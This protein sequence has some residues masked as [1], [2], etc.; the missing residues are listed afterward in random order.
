MNRPRGYFGAP[1]DVILIDGRTPEGLPPGVPAKWRAPMSFA[2]LD[3]RPIVCDFNQ[4]RIVA[5]EW[6]LKDKHVAIAELT[7]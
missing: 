4:E 7:Y 5:R 1:R 6:P 2:T 3:D